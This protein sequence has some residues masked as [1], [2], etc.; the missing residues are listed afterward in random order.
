[1]PFGACRSLGLRALSA[2]PLGDLVEDSRLPPTRQI[3]EATG[4]E[5]CLVRSRK[6]RRAQLAHRGG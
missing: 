2:E 5:Q 1:M 4:R 6:L 3:L